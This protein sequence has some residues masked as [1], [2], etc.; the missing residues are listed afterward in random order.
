MPRVK[1]LAFLLGLY[2]PILLFGL[3]LPRGTAAG[4]N[5]ASMGVIR[6]LIHEILFLTGPPEIFLNFVLFIPFFF[7]ILILAPT[8]SPDRAV[9]V[10]CLTSATAEVVQS[11]IPGRVSSMRDFFAN[12]LGVVI[13]MILLNAYAKS[14]KPE[15]RA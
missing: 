8:L 4:N 10:S 13:A 5:S 14:A 3:L 9:I 12:S 7:A 11:Q 6:R 1:P 15:S 2:I